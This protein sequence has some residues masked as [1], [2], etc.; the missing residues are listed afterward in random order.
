MHKTQQGVL[1]SV[2]QVYQTIKTRKL[3]VAYSGGLDS[4]VL[5]HALAMQRPS[6]IQLA[7]IHVHHGLQPEADSWVTHCQQVCARLGVQLHLHYVEVDPT[8]NL[9]AAAR[10]ARYQA[11]AE[12]LVF[13][14][15]IC[16]AHHQRDQA[17]TF[18]L[19][20][21][22]GAG[23]DG[24]SAM[25]ERRPL[26]FNHQ[27][28]LIRPLLNVA[29]ADIQAYA[30]QHDLAWVDDPMNQSKDYRRNYVRHQ[31]LPDFSQVWDEPE[32]KIAQA[33]AHLAEAS[34]LLKSLAQQDLQTIEHD[35]AKLN[36]H[37]LQSISWSR[38]KKMYCVI[39]L[40]KC[41]KSRW[42]KP[43]LIG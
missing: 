11:F 1:D 20:L 39:G 10:K 24:L 5:L 30:Q 2:K 40:K 42:I 25:P 34:E 7:A 28:W 33:C 43:V 16:T 27:A 36:W 22:R 23:L 13:D 17:E 8:Q 4:H 32:A 41:I 15:V 18:M 37:D 35:S 3:Y 26:S 21:M 9:E 31:I 19:N 14:D 6:H 29:Y 38:Q 12:T